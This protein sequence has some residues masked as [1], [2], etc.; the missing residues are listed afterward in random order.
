MDI[1][2]SKKIHSLSFKASGSADIKSHE[3][4]FGFEFE[5]RED[6]YWQFN[7]WRSIWL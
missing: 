5:Q 4:S 1:L 2:L 6:Y 3:L 7:A